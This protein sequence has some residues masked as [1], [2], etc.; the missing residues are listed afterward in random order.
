[1][2]ECMICYINQKLDDFKILGCSHKLC[3]GCYLQLQTETCPYCRAPFIYLQQE[4]EIV[5]FVD[6][7]YIPIDGHTPRQKTYRRRR[8]NLTYEEISE[9]RNMIK[10]RCKKKWKSKDGRLNKTKWYNLD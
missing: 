9:R 5:H 2:E 10:K 6:E 7:V 4:R 1:M 3:T 8:R